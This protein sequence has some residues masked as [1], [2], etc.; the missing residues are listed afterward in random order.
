MFTD[1]FGKATISNQ[2]FESVFIEDNGSLP[3]FP[4]RTRESISDVNISPSIVL[5]T[6]RKLKGNAAAGP[7]GLPPILFK[8]T[9]SNIAYPLAL[10]FRSFIDLHAL[11][12][13]WKLSHITPVF[14]KG[15]P[16]DPSNYRPISLTSC[17]CKVME[18]IIAQDLLNFLHMHKLIGWSKNNMVF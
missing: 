13:E 1:D 14:K 8:E 3:D 6:L 10:M 15:S 17:C 16:I 9:T 2:Y 11:P 5:R 12:S 4:F 18:S 7:D